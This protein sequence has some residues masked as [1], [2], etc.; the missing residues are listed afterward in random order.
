MGD[1]QDDGVS[2]QGDGKYDPGVNPLEDTIADPEEADNKIT[3]MIQLSLWIIN[4]HST[5]NMIVVSMTWK[6]GRSWLLV[7]I[8]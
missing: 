2:Q 8:T 4:N 6:K 3:T 7:E 5:T 1:E